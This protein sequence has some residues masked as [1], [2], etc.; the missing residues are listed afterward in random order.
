M[1]SLLKYGGG[2]GMLPFAEVS[3]PIIL[4]FCHDGGRVSLYRHSRGHLRGARRKRGRPNRGRLP[5]RFTA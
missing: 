1:E 2:I 4:L 3:N 5:R